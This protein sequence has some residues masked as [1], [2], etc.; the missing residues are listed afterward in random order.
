MPPEAASSVMQGRPLGLELLAAG[1]LK[2][3]KH[4]W[5]VSHGVMG[6]SRGGE[7]GRLAFWLAGVVQA[8]ATVSGGGGGERHLPR[9]GAFVAGLAEKSQG[10]IDTFVLGPL[11]ADML[12]LVAVWQVC[13][14]LL[15]A[16]MKDKPLILVPQRS[17]RSSSIRCPAR[18]AQVSM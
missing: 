11:K 3:A 4:L 16:A 17:K 1:P 12:P 6:G 10:A 15:E 14:S 7:V 8:Q 9:E 13:H 2:L 5:S 18:V